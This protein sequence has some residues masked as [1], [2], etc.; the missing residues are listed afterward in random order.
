M[1]Y[2]IIVVSSKGGVGK[3]TVSMQLITP[4][5]YELNNKEVL[6]YYECDDENKDSLSFGDSKLIERE[7]II[8]S[9]PILRE[10]L[11]EIFF[12]DKAICMDIGGNK[13][14]NIVLDSLDESG[15]IHYIDLAVI[16]L[17]DGEQDGINAIVIYNKIIAMN[18]NM[19]FLFIL[20]RA[21]NL[22]FLHYQLNNF[23]GDIR[24]IFT[25]I[26]PVQGY[27]EEKDK[28]NYIG[29]IDDDILKYSRRFGLTVYEIANQNRDFMKQF[30]LKNK[31]I[32]NEQEA[33]LISFKNYVEKD[34][35]RYYKDIFI[36]AFDKINKIIKKEK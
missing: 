9:S 31:N 30:H 12:Q 11:S 34:A 18:S 3:S 2:K 19:K 32:T 5:L 33:K 35:K 14:T 36:K 16:P 25:N 7:Q 10:K 22:K 29:L 27:T 13:S 1:S 23:F 20:N 26:D 4:F 21:K 6:S 17:L 24:G 15:A 8:V 28:E